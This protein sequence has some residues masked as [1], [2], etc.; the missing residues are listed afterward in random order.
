[1]EQES[2]QSIS[3]PLRNIYKPKH[4][5]GRLR[6][7]VILCLSTGW[8]LSE[9]VS[10]AQADVEAGLH[11]AAHTHLHLGL[12]KRG[13]ERNGMEQNGREGRE[14]KYIEWNQMGWNGMDD[15]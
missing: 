14:G 13:I 5:K 10:C 8:Y 1:M 7:L 12:L 6:F 3:S 4:L 11:N 2:Y 15:L 9:E